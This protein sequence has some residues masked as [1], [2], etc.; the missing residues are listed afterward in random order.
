MSSSTLARTAPVE[1]PGVR[2]SSPGAT[3]DSLLCHYGDGQKV[4]VYL[5]L[6]WGQI[7]WCSKHLAHI[8]D[9][10]ARLYKEGS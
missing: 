6:A 9:W 10:P 1:G 5:D 4:A 3:P 7:G 8:G 2:G